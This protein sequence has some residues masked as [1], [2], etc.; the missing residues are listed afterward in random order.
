M[1]NSICLILPYFGRFHSYFERWLRSVAFNDSISFLI[2]TNDRTP[3]E[4]PQNV[5]VEYCDFMEFAQRFQDYFDFEVSL[6]TP[7]KLCDFRPAYGTVLQEYLKDYMFW[8]HCDCD[9]IFGD[10]RTFFSNEILDVHD[11]ILSRGHLTLYRNIDG[12]NNFFMR[13]SVGVNAW[14]KV[15]SSPTSFA[16]DEWS[17]GTGVSELWSRIMPEKVYDEI[18]FDDINPMKGHFSS[19]QKKDEYKDFFVFHYSNG[20]LYR[21]FFNLKTRSIEKEATCYVHFQ[22]RFFIDNASSKDEFIIVPNSFEEYKTINKEDLLKWGQHR[23]F[24]SQYYKIRY[25]NLRRKIKG[26][27]YK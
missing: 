7:Y 5:H 20:S 14:K 9:L 17:A 26:F 2:F 11:K 16:Y 21:I 8:G 13:E 23:I 6:K 18:I 22:K 15:F 10:I 1:K 19:S 12:V 4:Y 24:Y 3:Y 25:A 27:L